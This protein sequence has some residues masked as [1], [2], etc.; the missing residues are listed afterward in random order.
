MPALPEAGQLARGQEQ[1]GAGGA[2]GSCPAQFPLPA[3]GVC[4]S[5]VEGWA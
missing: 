4:A 1:G 2:E 3:L 5:R